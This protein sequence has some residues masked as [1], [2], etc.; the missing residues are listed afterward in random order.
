M[1]GPAIG[2][3]SPP[4]TSIFAMS[5][6]IGITTHAAGQKTLGFDFSGDARRRGVLLTDYPTTSKSAPTADS[7]S[8]NFS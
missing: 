4:M 1:Y 2:R 3:F 5:P 7:L 6:V 8:K